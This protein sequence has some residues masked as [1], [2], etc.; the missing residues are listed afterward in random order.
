MFSHVTL[1]PYVGPLVRINNASVAL[2]TATVL[3]GSSEASHMDCFVVVYRKLRPA[4]QGERN[5]YLCLD[6]DR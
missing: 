2:N 5:N 4:D 1:E 6:Q 3:V